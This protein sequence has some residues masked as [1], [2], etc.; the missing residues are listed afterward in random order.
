MLVLFYYLS[1]NHRR[2]DSKVSVLNRNQYNT[3]LRHRYAVP[4]AELE[5]ILLQ[6]PDIADAGVIGIESLAEA[7]ELP[8]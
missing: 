4:P 8:R 1:P 5:S 6:H 3:Q 2:R 7:T